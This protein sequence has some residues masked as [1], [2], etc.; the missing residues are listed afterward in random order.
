MVM[1]MFIITPYIFYYVVSLSK[2]DEEFQ[3]I[4]IIAFIDG[5]PIISLLATLYQR[6]IARILYSV[7]LLTSSLYIFKF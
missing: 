5:S 4:E 6:V 2:L 7:V 3:K 1:D